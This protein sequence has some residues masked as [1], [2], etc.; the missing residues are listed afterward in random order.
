MNSALIQYYRCPPSTARFNLNGGTGI[1]NGYFRFGESAICNGTLY[2]HPTSANAGANLYDAA[3]AVEV[4]NQTIQLPFDPDEVADTLR[5]ER[6]VPD[7]RAPGTL[8]ALAQA[9][10]SIRPLLP[11]SIRRQL[12]KFHFKGWERR[13]F[14]HW[15]VDCSVDHLMQQLLLQAIRAGG[16]ERIP[17]IWFWPKSAPCCAIM[18][19]DVETT[20]GRDFTP[21]L[22]D[23]DDSFGIKASFQVI[24]EQRYIVSPDFLQ[25]VR[26]RGFEIVVHDLNHDGHLYQDRKEFLE[27]A[28]RINAYGRQYGAQG[29]RAGALYRKQVWYD[30]LDFAFDMSVPN[31]A[32]LD[33]QPG[34]CCTVMPYF[35]GN[36][37]ELPVTT[38]QDYT[39]FNILE[40]ENT[41]LWQQQ[42]SIIMENHGLMSFIAHPDYLETPQRVRVYRQLLEHLA[43][44]RDESNVWIAKPGEVNSWWRKR[45]AME[46]V[47]QGNEWRVAGDGSDSACVAFAREEE[48]RLVFS[49]QSVSGDEVELA[50]ASSAERLSLNHIQTSQGIPQPL[51][52]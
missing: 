34:G 37:L 25:S 42:M 12:Q 31:V 43:R 18:T 21:A 46:L 6:Y 49:L 27:R 5:S 45:A 3:Q 33:P 44:L 39:L 7:W 1:S 15:P 11:I 9:Y 41:D 47:K 24:P 14:P 16:A 19:H 22:M 23:I 51:S 30:A 40:Q 29:F 13:P 2:G 48:G 35:L 4:K 32:H 50:S 36:I 20:L 8:S 17:F 26:D 38:S 52:V 28:V 10:Y